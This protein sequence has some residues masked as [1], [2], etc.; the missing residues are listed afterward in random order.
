MTAEKTIRK[1]TT[2]TMGMTTTMNQASPIASKVSGLTLKG[3]VLF[4]GVGGHGMGGPAAQ[5]IVKGAYGQRRAEVFLRFL[6]QLRDLGDD[7]LMFSVDLTQI[8]GDDEILA[9]DRDVVELDVH[10]RRERQDSGLK[11]WPRY[12]ARD[13]GQ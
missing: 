6:C 1:T 4:A 5:C 12:G 8:E 2:P 10:S 7:R 11:N 9:R 3:A 13:T